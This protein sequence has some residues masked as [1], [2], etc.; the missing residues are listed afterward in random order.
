MMAAC[1]ADGP[2]NDMVDV[3]LWTTGP[4][5]YVRIFT[6]VTRVEVGT[7]QR[8]TG[9]A[10]TGFRL[11]PVAA[12]NFNI[13]NLN[14]G[15]ARV[16][17]LEIDGSGVTAS[18]AIR[19]ITIQN[20]LSN[21]GDIRIDSCIIHDLHTTLSG[22]PSEAT[23]G[24]FDV[25]TIA[26]SGPPLLITNNVIYDITNNV[27]EGHI[28]GM[29]VGSRAT[30][31][32]Y[33]NTVYSIN[34]MGNGIISGPAWGIYT[35]AWPAASGNATLIATNNYVGDVRAPFD[36]GGNH[37]C[38]DAEAPG[39]VTTQS[40]NVSSDTTAVGQ[41]LK[42]AYA[43]YFQNI[44]SGLEDLHLR[45]TSLALWGSS[46]TDLSTTFTQDVDYQVRTAPWDIG[47]D[48]FGITTAVGLSSFEAAPSDGAVDLLWRTGSEVDN[49]GFHVWRGAAADGP[50]TRL[51]SSLIPGLGLLRDGRQLLVARL[52]PPERHPLLLPSRGRGH[53]V[54]LHLPRPRLRR[55]AG[56]SRRRPSPEGGGSG[57]SGGSGW[58]RRRLCVLLL[59]VLGPRPARLVGLVHL[60]DPRRPRGH[61]LPRPLAFFSLRS[62]RARDRRLPHRTR[63]H[64]PRP[65]PPPRLRL[66]LRPAGTGAALEARPPRRRRRPPGPHRLHPGAR[67]PL[68][69]RTPRRRR[70]I[71]PGRRRSRRHRATRPPGSR[72]SPLPRCIPSRPGPTRRRGLPGRGQDPRPRADAPAL[73]RLARRPRPLPTPHRPRRLR[74]GR[75]LRDRT[76]T[77]RTTTP[78]LTTRLECLRLPRHVAEG[79]AL[80]RLRDALPRTLPAPRP[81]LAATHRTA[82]PSSPVSDAAPRGDSGADA[83]P[84]GD[85]PFFVLPQGPSFGP[86]GRLFFH[87]D[88]TA[89]STSFSAET[90]YALERGSAG[91][92]MA[93][94]NAAVDGSEGVSSRG[95]RLLRDQPPLRS[96]RP[97]HP[98]PLA[99]G[100][101]R[102]RREQDQAL[103]PRR[104]RPLLARDRPARR[105]PPGRL[106]RR[107][108]RGPPRPALPQRGPRGRGDL[109]RRRA[110]PYGGGRARLAPRGG[111]RA[112]RHERGRHRA[113]PPA[114]SST[115]ST[116][117]IPR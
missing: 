98:G 114:S 19:G 54:G 81:R 72:A 117:S 108:R 7:S 42:T 2:M 87:V 80:R 14:T 75:A 52:G 105:P 8:H 106:R 60:R 49:L 55:A 48:E 25:Q 53:E 1:Y 76:G 10:G 4:S 83:A 115:A 101:P 47:A 18:Q 34:N 88:A 36:P 13:V 103:R 65:R 89:S 9:V 44:N 97:R 24:I 69:L 51:T 112:A 77:P 94:G 84:R 59:P 6:P 39:G 20:G 67:Q 41:T 58:L 111:E 11:A 16:E 91:V 12:G 57:G 113:S 85:I 110:S 86:G 96:R 61:V 26:N 93:L 70:R 33:N 90:V 79:P 116:S 37:W 71:P 29:H 15:Y 78:R 104:P 63:R 107:L 17:G 21:V 50:W 31:Y 64:G 38:F 82:D 28:A 23:M 3:T 99:V 95:V 73:R 35:K 109:R 62:R 46:G 30:S 22:I 32:A 27:L 40:N 45:N 74:R 43:T 100:V 56:G 66:A 102:L 5:N 92:R 68:L